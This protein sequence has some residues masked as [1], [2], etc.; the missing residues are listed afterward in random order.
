MGYASAISV[1][2]LLVIYGF[3]KLAWRLFGD[4]D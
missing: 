3:S 2:L 1:V 4:K